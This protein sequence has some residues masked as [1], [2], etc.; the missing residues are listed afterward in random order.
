[1]SSS[2]RL[3][4]CDDDVGVIVVALGVCMVVVLLNDSVS[5]AMADRIA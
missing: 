3:C 5:D 1:L 4:I 2:N